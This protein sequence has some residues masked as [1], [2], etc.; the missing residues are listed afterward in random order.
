MQN[1]QT[2]RYTSSPS[3][4]HYSPSVPISVYRELAAE[5]QTS[6]ATIES[7]KSQNQQLVKQNQQ[8]RQEIEKVVQTAQNLQEI[9]TSLGSVGSANGVEGVRSR[10]GLPPQP[11]PRP[12]SSA[13][14]PPRVTSVPA[15]EFPPSYPPT[16]PTP[17]P[18]TETLVIE[19]EEPRPRRSGSSDGVSEVNGW[20]LIAFISIIVLTAFGAGFWIVRPMLNN[21][22]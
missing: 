9:V 21:N 20:W 2:D 13:P 14:P 12:A 4:N 18:Y 16:E 22:K 17:P 5:L 3:A 7:L 8:L 6:K 1:P 19:Q 10:S 11:E 15:S